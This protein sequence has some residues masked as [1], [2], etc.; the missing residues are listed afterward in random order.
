MTPEHLLDMI[1]E[2][3]IPSHEPVFERHDIVYLRFSSTYFNCGVVSED[4]SNDG[5]QVCQVIQRLQSD[6][7]G[8]V[9]EGL[10]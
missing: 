7:N 5:I 8:V 6:G 1:P 9:G 3:A 10:E 4:L 2:L